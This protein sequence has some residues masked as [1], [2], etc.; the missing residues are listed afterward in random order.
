MDNNKFINFNVVSG[1]HNSPPYEWSDGIFQRFKPVSG[2]FD[3]SSNFFG[4]KQCVSNQTGRAFG[5]NTCGFWFPNQ[6]TNQHVSVNHDTKITGALFPTLKGS[7]SPPQDRIIQGVANI[8]G[9]WRNT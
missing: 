3:T 2:P 8:G 7:T 1:R 9:T 5:G 6:F 4:D